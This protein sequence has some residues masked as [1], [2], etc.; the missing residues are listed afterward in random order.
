MNRQELI[1]QIKSKQSYLCVGLDTDIDKIPA[2]LK[3]EKDPV[4]EFNKRIIDATE[5]YAV[6]Y[7]P[8]LAFYEALGSKGWESLEKTIDY[9]P[10]NIFT[11]ADAKRGDIGN[12]SSLYAKAFFETYN[13]DS[14]TVAP[15]MGEDSVKPFL[16]FKD[17]WAIVLAH[18]SNAG[19]TNFQLI[20]SNKDG[21]YVYEEVIKQTQHW[22]NA[23]NMMYVV[24]ATQADKIG[25]IRKLAQD[26]FFLVPGVG[27][28]GGDLKQVSHQGF[29]KDVGLLVNASRSIIYASQD[30]AFEKAAEKE[31]AKIQT[32]MKILL[33]EFNL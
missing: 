1:A 19:A 27:A 5:K 4:F 24:G 32:E 12:T 13:F 16:Q 28:Q 11:I 29:N 8:N 7:K 31:A 20:Q 30:H 18:T 22:G 33:Q 15:Y 14:V 6:A 9:L 2:H 25:S 3:R 17:K 26:Y 21:S 23:N 10:K